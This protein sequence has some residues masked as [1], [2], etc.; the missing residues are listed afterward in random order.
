MRFKG[1]LDRQ[2]VAKT[3]IAGSRRSSPVASRKAWPHRKNRVDSLPTIPNNVGGR[4]KRGR[5][6]FGLTI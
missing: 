2:R 6:K 3:V 4:N 5:R 1:A